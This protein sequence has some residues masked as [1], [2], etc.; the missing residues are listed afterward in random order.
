MART[1]KDEYISKAEPYFSLN[2]EIL[3]D[4][5]RGECYHLY[6]EEQYNRFN[7]YP[8]PDMQKSDLSNDMIDILR[9]V[10]QKNVL[11]DLKKIINDLI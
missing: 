7:D 10:F 4:F 9:M 1:L 5:Q 6:T 3:L 2:E 11:R 8:I